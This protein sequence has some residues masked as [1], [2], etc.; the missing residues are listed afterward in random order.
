MNLK[1]G[2]SYNLAQIFSD[3]KKVYIPD[4]QRDYCW[5]NG[6]KEGNKVYCFLQSLKSLYLKDKETPSN[7]RIHLGLLYGYIE[8]NNPGRILL[9]DGQ[10]RL[11][12]LFLILGMLNRESGNNT[13]QQLLISD[14][15]LKDDDREPY[16]QYAIRESTMAFL[17]DL[18]CHFFLSSND[19]VMVSDLT[20]KRWYCSKYSNDP[21]ICS[22]MEALRVVE[23]FVCEQKTN[24]VCNWGF[25]EFIA[26][27]KFISERLDFMYYDLGT[28]S[29]GEKTFVV[30]NNAGEPL[31]PIENLKPFMVKNKSDCEKWEDMDD[32]FWKNRSQYDTSDPGMQEFFRVVYYLEYRNGVERSEEKTK[33]LASIL[34]DEDYHFPYKEFSMDAVWCYFEALKRLNINSVYETKQTEKVYAEFI[35]ALLYAKKFPTAQVEDISRIKHAFRNTTQYRNT[36]KIESALSLV[37]AMPSADILSFLDCYTELMKY[38]E[39]KEL[40]TKL[41]TIRNN[42]AIRSE[43]ESLFK[44]VENHGVWHGEIKMLID[45]AG[46]PD[47]FSLPSFLRLYENSIRLFGDEE[48][49]QRDVCVRPDV[50]RL[51]LSYG[52]SGVMKDGRWLR[53]AGVSWKKYLLDQ[54]KTQLL[55]QLLC[56]NDSEDAIQFHLNNYQDKSNR[57]YPLISN[58]EWFEHSWYCIIKNIN[59]NLAV[60]PHRCQQRDGFNDVFL[61]GTSRLDACHQYAS[62]SRFY[63][64]NEYIYTRNSKQGVGINLHGD[65]N[66]VY[67]YLYNEN[68]RNT[69]GKEF[70]VIIHGYQF[71]TTDNK[72]YKSKVVTAQESESVVS[73]A[74]EIMGRIC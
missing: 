55:H 24:E 36:Y 6:E 26:F 34:S 54:K 46:G 41:M 74:L 42:M 61:V 50:L 37:E 59:N 57:Y 70:D 22:M 27:G 40:T 71:E 52:I 63:Y 8:D 56:E 73:M 19:K 10:Q 20:E 60:I 58:G 28:R 72:F 11:T 17:S 45:W 4:L 7:D 49:S 18:V 65:K 64:N 38:D 5:G 53:N 35:P 44:K 12:T 9:C 67:F 62:W 3:D 29:N 39:R 15:E 47:S 69:I 16:L 1:T 21:S 30:I 25:D 13:F 2:E 66:G 33:F 23:H 43:L 31:T 48:E 51:L 14:R 32:W 68:E